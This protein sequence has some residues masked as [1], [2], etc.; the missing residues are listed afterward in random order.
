MREGNLELGKGM[1]ACGKRVANI[2][3]P[4]ESALRLLPGFGIIQL[5]ELSPLVDKD[6][7]N[8][9]VKDRPNDLLLCRV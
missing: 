9:Q 2:A 8:A 6:G 3:G 7:G 5:T 1:V 4:I